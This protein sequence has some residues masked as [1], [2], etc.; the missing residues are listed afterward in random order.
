M[1]CGGGGW[2]GVDTCNVCVYVSVC[3]CC[4]CV[5]VCVDLCF[6]CVCVCECVCVC[7]VWLT[8]VTSVMSFWTTLQV[9]PK[10]QPSELSMFVVGIFK[11]IEN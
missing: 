11:N 4:V 10:F 5:A 2:G 1:L 6:V 8:P 3:V 7:V 9:G